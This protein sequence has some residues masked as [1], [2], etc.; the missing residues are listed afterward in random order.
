MDEDKIYKKLKQIRKERGL[1]LNSLAEK[2]GADYQQI[3]RIER[4]KSKLTIDVLMKMAEALDTPIHE[5]VQ[6][7]PKMEKI[8]IAKKSVP[9]LM[10]DSS[11]PDWLAVILEKIEMVI[12]ETQAHL[13]PQAKALLTSQMYLQALQMQ[14]VKID[15]S[16]IQTFIEASIKMMKIL[17]ID[18]KPDRLS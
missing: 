16:V 14:N 10:D 6:V 9:L 18:L 5:I 15:P 11:N 2:M 3:S 7:L 13:R 12:Q 4:G 17:M 8:S 1:T